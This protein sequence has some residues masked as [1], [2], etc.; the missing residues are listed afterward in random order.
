MVVRML[1]KSSRAPCQDVPV[2][3]ADLIWNRAALESGGA[4]PGPGDLSLADAPAFH[5]LVMNGGMLDAAERLSVEDHV[6]VAAAYRWLGLE[7]MADLVASVGQLTAAKACTISS[8][9]L[10]ARGS[11]WKVTTGHILADEHC[12]SRR[13]VVVFCGECGCP[14]GA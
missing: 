13:F 7:A 10:G 6:K 8:T 5:G 4:S 9:C 11:T 3:A 1:G 12:L 2:D 14:Y